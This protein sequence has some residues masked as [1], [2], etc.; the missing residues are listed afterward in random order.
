MSLSDTSS[1]SRSAD[2]L[3]LPA[4]RA[5]TGAVGGGHLPGVRRRHGEIGAR[6][7]AALSSTASRAG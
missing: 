2:A 3:V 5:T 1:M 4:N 6:G 7:S